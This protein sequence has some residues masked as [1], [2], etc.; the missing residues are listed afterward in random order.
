MLDTN[1][2]AYTDATVF[3]EHFSHLLVIIALMCKKI[4]PSESA[5]YTVHRHL[6]YILGL[7]SNFVCRSVLNFRIFMYVLTVN[8]KIL[9]VALGMEVAQ[10]I[11]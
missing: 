11:K 9:I 10:S 8:Y 3:N 2:I 7:K 6:Q 5:G 1:V 4:V